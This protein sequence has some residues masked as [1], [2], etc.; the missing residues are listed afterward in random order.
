MVFLVSHL[1]Y[2]CLGCS[3]WWS[4]LLNLVYSSHI[5]I[6]FYISWPQVGY[7]CSCYLFVEVNRPLQIG[8]LRYFCQKTPWVDCYC[9]E[10]LEYC[11]RQ[12]NQKY[13]EVSEKLHKFVSFPQSYSDIFVLES[14][15]P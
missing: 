10:L 6:T 4:S 5:P 9:L 13:V 3:C 1:F 15:V 14:S 7:Y 2:K 8:D 11:V 12:L